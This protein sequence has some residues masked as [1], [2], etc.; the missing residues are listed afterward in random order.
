MENVL[1][2]GKSEVFK[3]LTT[4]SMEDFKLRLLKEKQELDEKA[5]K[6]GDFINGDKIDKLPPE[7]KV[8]L[9][10]Q[11]DVMKTYS[12]ILFMRLTYMGIEL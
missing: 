11:Y 12:N 6:L 10:V 8:L 1:K 7:Q 4:S 5:K 2:T 9:G 3:E